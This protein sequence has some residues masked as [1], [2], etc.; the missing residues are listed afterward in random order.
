MK[1]SVYIITFN[2]E[3]RLEK[4]LQSAIQ[5]ADEIIVVDSGS[6]DGT[7]KIAKKYNCKFIYNKWIS[8]SNQKHFAQQQCSSDWVLNLDADEVLSPEI[9]QAINK[10]KESF[11]YNAYYLNLIDMNPTDIKPRRFG[12]R[13][14]I[15]RLYNRNFANM[16]K[17]AMNKDRIAVNKNE[18]IGKMN[19]LVYHYCFLS[20]EKAVQKY[21]IHSS[22]LVKTA[23]KNN[24]HYSKLRL[25]TEFPRQFIC[26]YFLKRYFVYG[27]YGFIQAMVLAYFRFLKIAKV[28][29][30]WNKSEN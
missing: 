28:I 29:S 14:N 9:I 22:E 16:P 11:K 2:E 10:E 15:I 17:D 25:I 30:Y 4:T 1:L 27:T 26:Y 8:Y 23:I 21:N 19:G 18:K 12:R 20:I 7:E 13:W 6:N 5:V 24:T 3:Q